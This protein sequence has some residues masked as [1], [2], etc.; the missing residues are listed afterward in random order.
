MELLGRLSEQ[1]APTL[2]NAFLY[3]TL[4]RQNAVQNAILL[5][6]PAGIVVIDDEFCISRLNDVIDNLFG[7][8]AE[9]YVGQ[10]L[11]SLLEAFGI[12]DNQKQVWHH[13]KALDSASRLP[14]A[15]RDFAP[16]YGNL[17]LPQSDR[18]MGRLISMQ[19]MLNWTRE[20]LASRISQIN[21]VLAG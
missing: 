17:N 5:G 15:F 16:D 8:H 18:V 13:L 6:S 9:D 19:I 12:D 2:E 1:L 14:P 7:V 20:D 3:T 10:P 11:S 4:E 21:D